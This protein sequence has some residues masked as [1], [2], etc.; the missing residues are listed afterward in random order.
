MTYATEDEIN[1]W[2]QAI[3][4]LHDTVA[5]N[6]GDERAAREAAANLWSGFG[7]QDAPGD[8]L[9]MF[10]Q[11]IEIGYLTALRDVRNGDLDNELADWRPE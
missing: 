3:A 1:D 7:Y 5:T 9:R 10:A 8:V 11:A 6:P 4:T 2:V